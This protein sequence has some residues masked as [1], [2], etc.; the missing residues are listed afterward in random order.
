MKAA[1]I[2]IA[3]FGLTAC[4]H[5]YYAPNTANVPLLTEQGEVKAN[6]SSIS[7]FES[8]ANGGELQVAYAPTGHFGIHAGGLHI[9][10]RENTSNETVESGS[11]GY[12]ELGV[13]Y[14]TTLD[15]K[16]QWVFEIYGGYGGGSV[17]NN[18][19]G[20]TT[21]RVG[22]NKMYIQPAIGYKAK[23]AEFAFA[24][25]IANVNWQVKRLTG[26]FDEFT[27]REIFYI[28]E[29]ENFFNFEPTLLVRAGGEVA[30][31]QFSLTFSP[32]YSNDYDIGPLREN[33][34]VGIGASFNVLTKKKPEDT[35]AEVK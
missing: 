13:G 16:R 35:K 34:L 11:G 27:A 26:G 32:D 1:I 20:G 3:V 10:K 15:K 2:V 19:G 12:G 17:Y 31:I 6:L 7:A 18:Y 25:K 33:L 8:R 5:V 30:K 22:I 21:S 28:I 14:F 29:H 24:P 9:G 4:N 23:N